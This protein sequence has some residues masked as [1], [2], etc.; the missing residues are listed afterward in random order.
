LKELGRKNY[1]SSAPTDLWPFFDTSLQQPKGH[2]KIPEHR[3]RIRK[4]LHDAFRIERKLHGTCILPE[5][6]HYSLAFVPRNAVVR[7]IRQ[8]GNSNATRVGTGNGNS[9]AANVP[10]TSSMDSSTCVAHPAASAPP[11]PG[12][13]SGMTAVD[14]HVSQHITSSNATDFDEI[15]SVLSALYSFIRATITI[16]QI[17]YAATTLYKATKGPQTAQYGYSA[18]RLTMTP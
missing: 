12:T 9:Q 3:S 18:F 2:K 16:V 8:N 5:N 4:F 7:S 13:D 1:H 15:P 14:N 17:L 6:G 10:S 11:T